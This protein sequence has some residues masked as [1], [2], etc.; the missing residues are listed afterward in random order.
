MGVTGVLETFGYLFYAVSPNRTTFEKIEDIPD[1]QLQVVPC[2][3]TLVLLEIFIKRI[4]K[5]PIRL[6][7]GITSISQ[8]MLSETTR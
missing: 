2:F 1:Y 7:D 5:D 6:N 3:V 4:Q 8:G